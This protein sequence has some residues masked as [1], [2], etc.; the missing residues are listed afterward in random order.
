M[1]L[2][3]KILAL[4][5][6]LAALWPMQVQAQEYDNAIGLRLGDPYGFSFKKYKSDTR[7]IEFILGTSGG[8]WY[9]NYYKRAFERLSLA[10]DNFYD[11]HRLDFTVAFAARYLKQKDFPDKVD[12]LKWYY[13]IGLG[14]R[15]AQVEY[16][17]LRRADIN[18]IHN[19]PKFFSNNLNFDAGPEG[20][21]GIEYTLYDAPITLYMETSLF[22]EII[23]NPFRF[24][25]Y[26]AFGIRYN[27]N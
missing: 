23:D 17:Y 2:K 22:G 3:V 24:R 8:N 1:K 15:L 19:A 12:G 9:T 20:I 13:G 25:F 10:D 5:L 21:L 7:A 6:L 26:G 4:F 14:L 27:F 16:R 11:G 18:D